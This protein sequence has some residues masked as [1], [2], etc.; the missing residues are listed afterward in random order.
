MTPHNRI[1]RGAAIALLTLNAFLVTGCTATS[2]TSD[3]LGSAVLDGLTTG[4]TS[5]LAALI[6][7]FVVTVAT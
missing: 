7:V 2:A 6:E 5:A 4:L 3:T 1:R